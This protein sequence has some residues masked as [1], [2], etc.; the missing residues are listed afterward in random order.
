MRSHPITLRRPG[1]DIQTPFDVAVVLPTIVRPSLTRALQSVFSQDFEGRIQILVGIDKPMFGMDTIDIPDEAVPENMAL[2]L[3]DLGYSTSERHGGLSEAWDGGYLR[4]ILSFM[5]NSRV[6]T[7]LDDDNWWAE[8]HLRHLYTAL[9]GHNWAYSLRWFVASDSSDVLAMDSW[10]SIGPGKGVYS[11][12][13]GGWVDPNCLMVRRGAIEPALPLWSR[14]ILGNQ[15]KMSADRHVYDYL[16]RNHPFPGFSDRASVFYQLN[17]E[18]P[19]HESR[20]E[21]M[22]KIRKN[23]TLI[24]PDYHP[25]S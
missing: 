25:P 13:L 21:N 18:D 9:E 1:G 14:P 20:M 6:I 4:T 7:Y 17:P 10:E 11:D 16:S 5:A 23:G 8:D 2:T 19:A 24:T 22:E 12:K 3:F 15:S